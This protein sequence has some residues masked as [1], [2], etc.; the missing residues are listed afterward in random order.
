MQ[1]PTVAA[2]IPKPQNTTKLSGPLAIASSSSRLSTRSPLSLGTLSTAGESNPWLAVGEDAAGKVSRKMNKAT[3][4]KDSRDSA[5]MATKVDRDRSKLTDAREADADDAHVEIDPTVV[6]SIAKVKATPQLS[7]PKSKKGG[8][9]KATAK[10]TMVEDG[11]GSSDEEDDQTQIDAQNGKGPA[12]FKQRDLV[13]RAFAGDNVVAVR[14][15]SI[16]SFCRLTTDTARW[17]TGL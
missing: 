11:V 6:L 15:S 1:V 9:A 7:V 14:L 3:V 2:A 8:G 13:A 5:R 4:G 17:L 12:A 10:S 16:R